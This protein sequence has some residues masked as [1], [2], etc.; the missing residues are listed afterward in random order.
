[1]GKIRQKLKETI[2]VNALSEK[3]LKCI[4]NIH[5]SGERELKLSR[6][7]RVLI[8]NYHAFRTALLKESIRKQVPE[9]D[10]QEI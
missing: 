10:D 4:I 8:K 3:K 6:P 9:L 7:N 1:M 2:N 5:E